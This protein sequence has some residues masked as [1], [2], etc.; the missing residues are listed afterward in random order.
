MQRP[1]FTVRL[2]DLERGKKHYELELPLAWLRDTFEG[3]EATVESAGTLVFDASVTARQVLV[4]GLARARVTMPC[5]R[6]LDPVTID[7]SA[8]VYLV[9]RPAATVRVA[10]Q[11][12][13]GSAAKRTSPPAPAPRAAEAAKRRPAQ[14]PESEL[15]EDEAAEDVYESDPID[16][17]GY[18]REFLLLELPLMPL[19]SDLRFEERP[20]IPPTPE[21][22]QGGESPPTVD[23]RLQPLAEIASRFRKTTKE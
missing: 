4:R 11:T 6:T 7:L 21:A 23:P 8:E 5:A 15:S 18:I 1:F 10:H 12:P 9:L 3:T 16:L 19:R 2:A 20:A 17:D 14:R 13:A 22:T